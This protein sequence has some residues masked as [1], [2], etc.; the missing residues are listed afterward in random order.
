MKYYE[1]YFDK[2][3]HLQLIKNH[4]QLNQLILNKLFHSNK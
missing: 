4:I 3:I 2:Y 1:L